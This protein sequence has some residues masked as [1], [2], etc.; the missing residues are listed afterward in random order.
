[1]SSSFTIP[2]EEIHLE[3]T[4][5]GGPG[6]QN[7]NKVAT[8]VQLRF[9][10]RQSPSLPED[11]KTRLMTLAGKR[12]T[13]DGILILQSRTYRTQEQNRAEVLLRFQDL[14]QHAAQ[15]PKTRRPTR[16][17]V[18]AKAARLFAKRR[19]AEIKRIRQYNPEEWE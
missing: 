17:G 14:L 8:A 10:I 6:G 16:P 11:V 19:R 5:A 15:R 9:D 1:M 3:F 18:T 2:E 13:E 7:V 12:V 4:R